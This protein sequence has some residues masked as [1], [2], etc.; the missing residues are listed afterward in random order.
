MS[1]LG[2]SFAPLFIPIERRL[3]T[4]A[5]FLWMGSFLFGA[6]LGSSV[7][8]Y[9]FCYTSYWWISI[10]YVSWFIWDRNTCNTGGRIVPFMRKL[11][12]WRHFRNF[13][14]VELVKTTDLDP[15]KTYLFTSQ[16]HGVLCAGAF[17]TFGTDA[18]S[19]S[20]VFNGLKSRLLVLEGQ[21][22]FPIYREF[23][24]SLG[25]CSASKSSMIHLFENEKSSAIVLVTG[26]VLEAMENNKNDIRLVLNRRKGFIKLALKYGVPLVPTFSFGEHCLYDIINNPVGSFLRRIQ[27]FSEKKISFS[28]IL[29]NGR[30]IFQ[31]NFGI[32][33][34]RN[35]ISVVVGKPLDIPKVDN[36][37][38]ELIEATHLRFI[39]SIQDL[40]NEYNPLYGDPKMNLIVS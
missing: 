30:G 25:A 4:L 20:K 31:Y 5:A 35:K 10:A 38:R 40:Y 6:L 17:A 33:P 22:W 16:P 32:V 34:R 27:E 11:F 28:P 36:P 23:L 14:P 39:Q 24:I 29:F 26:G 7:I 1:L 3:Q 8:L 18:L 12:L 37:S 2:L 13:F 21:F 9:L 19:F 15:N